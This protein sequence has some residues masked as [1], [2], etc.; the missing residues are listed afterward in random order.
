M[1]EV[2]IRISKNAGTLGFLPNQID[3]KGNFIFFSPSAQPECMETTEPNNVVPPSE[4]RFWNA[5]CLYQN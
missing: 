3:L 4:P 2:E 5:I 1:T